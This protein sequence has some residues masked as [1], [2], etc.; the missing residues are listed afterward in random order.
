[1][2]L[3]VGL[4]HGWSIMSRGSTFYIAPEASMWP[5][6]LVLYSSVIQSNM[7]IIDPSKVASNLKW[8]VARIMKI[9]EYWLQTMILNLDLS[10]SIWNTVSLYMFNL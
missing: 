3:S 6:T 8:I 7:V 5:R 4:L 2:F 10:W 9:E 1:M